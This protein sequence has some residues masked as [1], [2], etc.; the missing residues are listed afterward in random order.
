MPVMSNVAIQ[1]VG[2]LAWDGTTAFNAD[3]R[4]HTRFAWSFEVTDT[5]VVDAVFN[6]QA[7][8]ASDADNCAPGTFANVKE[9]PLCDQGDASADLTITIP[10]GTPAGTVCGGTIPCKSGAFIR[11]VSASG[12]TGN[13]RA[14]LVRNGPKMA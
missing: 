2:T 8:P 3:T 10:A 5:I 14:V 6:V 13:V 4:K 1:N 9:T 11:L 12:D 7:A